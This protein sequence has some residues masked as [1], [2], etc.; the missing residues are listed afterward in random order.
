MN[1]APRSQML[2][3]ARTSASDDK[4]LYAGEISWK[5]SETTQSHCWRRL[6]SQCGARPFPMIGMW[7]QGAPQ[8]P[9]ADSDDQHLA[10]LLQH[11][12]AAC[13][14]DCPLQDGEPRQHDDD[15]RT[16]MGDEPDDTL[17]YSAS[18]IASPRMMRANCASP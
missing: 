14:A 11:W 7:T 12:G 13:T 4:D 16:N 9:S 17:Q 2:R 18:G 8:K 10:D 15:G 5:G 3:K 6:E 1:F